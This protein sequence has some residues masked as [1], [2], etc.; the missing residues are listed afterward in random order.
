[1]S[2]QNDDALSG[3]LEFINQQLDMTGLTTRLSDAEIERS[4]MPL[5]RGDIYRET[6]SVVDHLMNSP[7][8]DHWRAQLAPFHREIRQ[9]LAQTVAA[10]MAERYPDRMSADEWLDVATLIITVAWL[11]RKHMDGDDHSLADN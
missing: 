9:C 3:F 2:D 1:M 7:Q 11:V 5:I 6:L 4:V 8:R 10:M